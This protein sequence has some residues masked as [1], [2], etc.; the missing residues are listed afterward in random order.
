M[1]T[2]SSRAIS[3]GSRT[4]AGMLILA[5]ALVGG[6]GCVAIQAVGDARHN[7]QLREQDE[8]RRQRIAELMPRAD[9]RDP[10]VDTELAEALVAA[11]LPR[12]LDVPRALDLLNRSAAAGYPMAQALL[13]DAL[14]NGRFMSTMYVGLPPGS[15]DRERGLALL[16]Q[17]ATHA[18]RYQIE[19]FDTLVAP[20]LIR[21][22]NELGRQLWRPGTEDEAALWRARAFLHCGDTDTAD[23]EWQTRS[24]SGTP[25]QRRR[26]LA[27][28]LLAPSSR[29]IAD[30]KARLTP[31]Q[32][33]D[34]ERAA[35]DLRRRVA[36]SEK[37]YPAPTHKELP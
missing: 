27:V 11:R 30:A 1:N 37:E 5:L 23:L 4:R 7:R 17:A 29:S 16:R 28:L 12:D 13:G 34:G 20:R 32:L 8:T 22:A 10:A 19:T 33:A 26:A 31:D 21:P 14:V 9:G 36:E 2:L 18:C 35:E 3:S 25:D 15:A 6:T 24:T